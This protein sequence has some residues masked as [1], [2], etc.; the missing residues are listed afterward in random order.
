EREWGNYAFTDEM[1]IE[2]GGLFG[3]STVWR[4]KGKEWHDDCVGVKKKRGVMVMC[5]GMISWNWKGPFWV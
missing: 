2:I 3:P 1:S 4:E 5:W